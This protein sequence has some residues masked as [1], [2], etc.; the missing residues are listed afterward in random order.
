MSKNP[1]TWSVNGR[2]HGKAPIPLL[3]IELQQSDKRMRR[4]PGDPPYGTPI[5]APLAIELIRNL[6]KEIDDAGLL[7]LKPQYDTMIKEAVK[8]GFTNVKP[9]L[10]NL[11]YKH[12]DW[13]E[14]LLKNSFSMTVDR[15]VI[16]KILS[17]PGCEGLRFYLCMKKEKEKESK[18]VPGDLSLVT[19]GVDMEIRDLNY[20]YDPKMHDLTNIP[21]IE[22]SSMN[23]EYKYILGKDPFDQAAT[24][25]DDIQPFV[26]FKYAN[27]KFKY[28]KP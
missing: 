19:V 24:T 18:N 9:K 23:I 16:L 21:D 6:W 8:E 22:N 4:K 13:L 15:N 2:K 20:E 5:D 28:K 27:H 11:V 1:I 17:Q 10:E 25:E 26:L 14:E 12:A 3:A 7:Q